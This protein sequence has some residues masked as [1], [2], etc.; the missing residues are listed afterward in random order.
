M[1]MCL[2]KTRIFRRKRERTTPLNTLVFL[3]SELVDHGIRW[4]LRNFLKAWDWSSLWASFPDG[5]PEPASEAWSQEDHRTEG[6]GRG[7][8]VGLCVC[9]PISS[10]NAFITFQGTYCSSLVVAES[11]WA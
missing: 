9:V 2:R 6:S 4:L 11:G 3:L 7:G 1:W 8:C 10:T 5:S